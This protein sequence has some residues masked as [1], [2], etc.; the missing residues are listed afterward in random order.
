[1]VVLAIESSCDETA[2]AIAKHTSDGGVELL[3]NV[4]H[5]QV[6]LHKV[7]GGVVPEVSARSHLE[8]INQVISKCLQDSE[9]SWDDIGAIAVTYGPGLSGSLLI[10][11]LT[12]RTLAITKAIPLYGLHHIYGHVYANFITSADADYRIPSSPPS[13]PVLALIVSGKHSQLMYFDKHFNGKIIGRAIDDAVGEAFD[14]AAKILG[15]PYPGGPAIAKAAASG[16]PAKYQLPI[17][18]TANK[19]DFSFSGL[20]T[21]LLRLAQREAGGNHTMPSFEV[22]QHL[23][24]RQVA[25]LAACFQSTAIKTLV[26][27]TVKACHQ[28]KPNSL[29]IGGGVA[30]NQELRRQLSESAPIE[31]LFTDPRLCTDN[32][33]MIAALACYQIEAGVKP[34]DPYKL[35]IAT[36]TDQLLAT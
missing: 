7:Y 23:S 5:S 33:A 22:S 6:D 36:N 8:V 13:L 15:L 9:L 12:A 2:V 32:A 26:E 4:V 35:E 28:H 1:M 21:A 18:K 29:I 17:A 3:A 31:P 10:G 20:K 30:A 16:N 14:K 11:V 34:S 25:D 24:D 19:Y 27:K